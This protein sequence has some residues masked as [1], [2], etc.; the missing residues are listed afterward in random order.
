MFTP[1]TQ[2]D[3]EV[4]LKTIGIGKVE[5]LFN[6]IPEKF[7]FPELKLPAS[8]TEMEAADELEGIADANGSTKTFL[9]FIGAGAYDHYVPAAVDMLLRRGEFYTAYT[10]YQPEISQ[11]TLQAIFEYQSLICELTG[12]DVANASHYDGATA[13]AEAVILAYHHFKG[14]RTKFLISRA[15]NPQYREV[16]R[17]YMRGSQEISI[18]GDDPETGID[19]SMEKLISR[20]DPNTA[21]VMVQYPDFFGRVIDYKPLIAAAHS[22]GALV[23]GDEVRVSAVDGPAAFLLLAARPLGEPVVQYGPFVMNTREEI[24][25]AI[26]DYQNGTLA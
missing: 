13:A 21:L 7:R 11:G 5:D 24:E 18:Q 25:Q 20:I 12:M 19:A 3:V 26:N 9:N 8:L 22:A 4:M 17:T 14:K 23:G 10:P 15:V 16:V 2:K 6:E 1:H